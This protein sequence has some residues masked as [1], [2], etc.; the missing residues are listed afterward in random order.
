M[1]TFDRYDEPGK[2][3]QTV[4]V[5]NGSPEMVLL[6]DGVVEPGAYRVEFVGLGRR[7][8]SRI[9]AMAPDLIVL[10][11][12]IDE[13]AGFQLLTMLKLDAATRDIPVLTFT[14]ECEGEEY[15]DA[16]AQASEEDELP[17]LRAEFRMN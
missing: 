7:V 8:H 3:P 5:V 15:L 16:L 1:T 17:A 2:S 4:A 13:P 9:R 11:T 10:C 14:T 12:R 6:L